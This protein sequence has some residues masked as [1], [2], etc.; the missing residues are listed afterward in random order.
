[1][2]KL[3]DS[4]TYGSGNIVVKSNDYVVTKPRNTWDT[5]F[6]LHDKKEKIVY[7]IDTSEVYDDEYLEE[8]EENGG[9][10][11][12]DILELN[13]DNIKDASWKTIQEFEAF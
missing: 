10:L 11:Y 8:Y 13:I 6:M 1:M 5:N 12:S 2:E 4:L 7:L 9:L 3:I